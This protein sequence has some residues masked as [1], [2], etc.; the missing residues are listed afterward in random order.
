MVVTTAKYGNWTTYVGTL[1]EVSGA[2]N[3]H[4]AKQDRTFIFSDGT[5][6]VG[7]VY[8]G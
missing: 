1:E 6:I 7:V 8:G 2:L 4:N 3:V 5:N